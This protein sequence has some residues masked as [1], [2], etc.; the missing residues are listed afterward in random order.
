VYWTVVSPAE[1]ETRKAAAAAA[2][3]RRKDVEARAIDAV[4]AGDPQSERD[5]AYANANA[6]DGY[7]EGQRTRE[8]RDG[9]FSYALKTAADRPVT[10]VATYRG[11]EGRRRSFDV[12]VDGERIATESLEY[13]PTEEL[14]RE[15]AIPESL[16]RGKDHVTVTFKAQPQA[17]AGAVI[18]VRTVPR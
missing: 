8:A 3:A 11:S 10:L 6:T 14:D 2:D 7:F 18:A 15:Y 4:A 16:T 1:W 9:W 13:H 17:T 12:L 5:H